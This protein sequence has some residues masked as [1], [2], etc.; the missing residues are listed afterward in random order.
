MC[1]KMHV[2]KNGGGWAVLAN[3]EGNAKMSAETFHYR[4]FDIPVD[5]LMLT[6]GGPETFDEI[7]K[8][9]IQHVNELIGYHSDSYVVEIGC[10]I[11]RDAIPL[12]GILG[13]NGRYLGIDIVEKSIEWCQANITPRHSNFSFV[14]FDVKDQLHNPLGTQ[15]VSVCCLPA[16]NQAADVI[17]GHSVFTHL[18]EDGIAVYLREFSR[19]LKKSGRAYASCFIVDDRIRRKLADSPATEWSLQFAHDWGDRCWINVPSVPLGAV[20]YTM[21]KMEELVAKAELEFDRPL[22]RGNWSGCFDQPDAA[23]DVVLLRR[24]SDDAA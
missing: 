17:I 1:R 6:G 12:T 15:D 7:V 13:S 16:P 20:T 8:L 21:D 22:V 5:L 9:H 11:G 3:T 18:L 4:G 14:H 23:Q 24:I 2:D 10:G 19:V